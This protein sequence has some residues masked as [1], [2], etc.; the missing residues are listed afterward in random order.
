MSSEQQLETLASFH[1]GAHRLVEQITDEQWDLPTPCSEW[2]VAQLV[3]HI[4]G[5]INVLASAAEREVPT[6]AD[7]ND[8]HSGSD[9]RGALKKATEKSQRAWNSPGALD[10]MVSIPGE[11]PASLCL[12][13]TLIDTGTHLWDLAHAIGADHDLSTS[14]IQLLDELNR[15]IVNDE[16][17]AGGGFGE[18]LDPSDGSGLAGMLAFV[19]RSA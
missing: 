6:L 2:N 17:R 15:Q 12:G 8:D 13:I 3:N 5:S 10:G 9:P 19:G 11:M 14:E 18:D 4:T 16:V 7:P 1:R